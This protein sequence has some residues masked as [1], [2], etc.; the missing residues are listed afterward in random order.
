MPINIVLV[1]LVILGIRITARQTVGVVIGFAGIVAIVSHGDPRVLTELSINTGDLLLWLAVLA[2][3][4]YTIYLP[5]AQKVLELI[6]LMT[7]LFAVG[8][9]TCLPLY[10]WETLV[11]GWALPL[12]WAAAWSIGYMGLFPSLLAQLF[13]ASA[14]SRVGANTAGYFIY[15]SP[16]FGTIGAIVLLGEAFAWFHA[17][18]IALIFTGIYLAARGPR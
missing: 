9:L 10:L 3:A 12:N 11:V 7:V 5:R 4:V 6:P 8:S 14:V 16:V 13:W 2:Y 1:S 18:G 17:L 15:L